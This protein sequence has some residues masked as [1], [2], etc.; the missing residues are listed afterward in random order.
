M[1]FSR[2]ISGTI[3]FV[4]NHT[5]IAIVLALGLLFFVYRKPK[6]FFALLFVALFLAGLFCMITSVTRSDSEQKRRLI[7]EEE[8]ESDNTPRSL[9]RNPL[10][11]AVTELCTHETRLPG[12]SE[13]LSFKS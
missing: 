3:S 4:Q 9:F 5:V 8:K 1:D 11:F 12:C 2:L 13:F 7:H 6:L 10:R